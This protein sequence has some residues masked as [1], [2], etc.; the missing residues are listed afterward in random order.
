MQSQSSLS[1][2][3]IQQRMK[4]FASRKW[5]GLSDSQQNLVKKA[6]GV[7]TY[8]WRWQIAMN[9]PY[10]AIFILD[11]TIPA[12]HKFDMNLLETVTSYIP[13]PAFISAW[14]GLS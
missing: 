8:K 11:R 2:E 6:W 14:L 5:S 10:L 7:I 13:I 12:V 4:E 9:V 1:Q 3:G